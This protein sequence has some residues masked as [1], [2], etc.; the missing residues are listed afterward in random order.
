MYEGGLRVPAVVGPQKIRGE[1]SSYPSGAVDI[2]HIAEI[3][4]LP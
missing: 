3:V 4:G 1:I 2:F